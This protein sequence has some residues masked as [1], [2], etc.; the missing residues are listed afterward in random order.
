MRH[1]TQNPT[2]SS[3]SEGAPLASRYGR[4]WL[5]IVRGSG[6]DRD[7][8]SLENKNS[9]VTIAVSS[10]PHLPGSR[11]HP[12]EQGAAVPGWR[13]SSQIELNAGPYP[14]RVSNE[15]H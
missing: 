2:L 12:K 9:T 3:R 5:S 6:A 14:V 7:F 1:G 10:R 13:V 4:P 15:V 11:A 8:G